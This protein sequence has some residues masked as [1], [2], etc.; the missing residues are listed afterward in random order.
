MFIKYQKIH[1]NMAKKCDVCSQ[2]IQTTFLGKI[3]GTTVNKNGKL[4]YVC[5]DCQKKHTEKHLKEAV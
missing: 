5:R 3:I 2:K 1:D 4:K